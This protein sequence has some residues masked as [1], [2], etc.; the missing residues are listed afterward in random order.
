MKTEL[1]DL[2]L[3]S[4]AVVALLSTWHERHRHVHDLVE[5][6][7]GQGHRLVLAGHSLIEAYSVLTRLP[8]PYRISASDAHELL[9]KNFAEVALLSLKSR[10]HWQVL[11]ECAA[12]GIAGGRVY[13]ALIARTARNGATPTLVTL[14]PKHFAA[15]ESSELAIA[16]P[17]DQ[18]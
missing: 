11:S 7:L 1:A 12:Q 18:W 15:F 14:N 6:R 3:D 13:D 4:S 2:V 9:R 8:T 17:M 10:E 16:S 5:E